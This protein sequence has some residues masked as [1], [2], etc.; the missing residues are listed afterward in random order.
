MALDR[1]Q[2]SCGYLGQDAWQQWKNVSKILLEDKKVVQ[3]VRVGAS[4][5]FG[6]SKLGR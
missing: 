4:G 1:Y 2:P 5:D 3:G 6:P